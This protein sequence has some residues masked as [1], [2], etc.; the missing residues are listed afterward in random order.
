[1]DNTCNISEIVTSERGTVLVEY[2]IAAVIMVIGLIPVVAYVTDTIKTRAELARTVHLGWCAP[3]PY[4]SG[5]ATK[6][7]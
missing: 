6:C 2:T 3:D 1:M 5:T 7:D 4:D